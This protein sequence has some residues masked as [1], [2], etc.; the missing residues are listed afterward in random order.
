MPVQQ[1]IVHKYIA[2]VQAAT[3]NDGHSGAVASGHTGK[4]DEQEEESSDGYRLTSLMPA[5]AAA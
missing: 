5:A 2:L 1:K 4:R 3:G